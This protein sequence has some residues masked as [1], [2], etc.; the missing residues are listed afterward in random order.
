M[1]LLVTCARG[2][3]SRCALDSTSSQRPSE[4]FLASDSLS[5]CACL[6]QVLVVTYRGELPRRAHRRKCL[7]P[8]EKVASIREP[9]EMF[10]LDSTSSHGPSEKVAGI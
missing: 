3:I 9:V 6:W 2:G 1:C 4:K 8:S 5:R 10:V 7:R